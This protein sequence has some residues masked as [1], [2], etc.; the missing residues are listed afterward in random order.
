MRPGRSAPFSDSP[1]SQ[2]GLARWMTWPL[3]LRHSTLKLAD[4][5]TSNWTDDAPT[6]RMAAG[7]RSGPRSAQAR[8]SASVVVRRARERRVGSPIGRTTR[9]VRGASRIVAPLQGRRIGPL[10]SVETH[11]DC[12]I[13][14]AG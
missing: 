9:G 10:L 8:V 1:T 2:D 5:P 4:W 6:T 12:R 13:E 11:E 14:Q 7:V 3:L